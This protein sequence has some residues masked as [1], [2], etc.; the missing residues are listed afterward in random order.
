MTYYELSISPDYVPEWGVV[1][2]V[3]EFFQN[4]LDEETRDADN[5]MFFSYDGDDQI[6]R[7]GNKHGKLDPKTLLLGYTEKHDQ[8]SMIGSYGEGYKIA[9]V[10]LLRLNKRLTFYNYGHRQVWRPRFVK[11]RKYGTLVPTFEVDR[12][13]IWQSVPDNDLVIEI[14]GITADEYDEIVESNL[15]LQEGCYARTSTQYGD[16][17]KDEKFKSKIFVGGLYI[18]DDLDLDLGVDFAPK[19]VKLERDRNMVNTFDVHWYVSKMIEETGD[20][21]LIEE[22]L[23]NHMGTYINYY[24]IPDIGN[25]IAKKFL[26][27]HGFDAVPVSDQKDAMFCKSKNTVIVSKPMKELILASKYYEDHFVPEV[28]DSTLISNQLIDFA[29]KIKVRLMDYEL[30]ELAA[31]IKKIQDRESVTSNTAIEDEKG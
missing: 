1:E 9:T 30:E 28:T 11:S 10:V 4:A 15:H 6:L 3:R 25:D 17:L 18:C 24:S 27:E 19:T 22:S 26:E 12:K 20:Q 31:I 16:L 13:Y 14:Q 2:A 29:A 21:D 7:I 23:S 8:V 5:K